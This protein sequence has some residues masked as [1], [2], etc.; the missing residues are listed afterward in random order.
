MNQLTIRGFDDELKE[1]IRKLAESENTSMNRAAL[2]LLRRGA[3]LS[4]GSGG[5]GKVGS[6][7]DHLIGTMS[8]EEADELEALI[9]EEFEKIDESMWQ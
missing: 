6:S 7:L 1:S 2:K 3:G 9:E 4:D 5:R 8:R